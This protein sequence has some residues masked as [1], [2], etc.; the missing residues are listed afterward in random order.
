M[1]WEGIEEALNR[2]RGER[3]RI[4]LQLADLD[5]N[6]AQRM[7]QGADPVGRTRERWVRAERSIH[8]LW[9]VY[10]AFEN[11]VDQAC[12]LRGSGGEDGSVRESLSRVLTG[13]A[14][15][16]PLEPRP[17]ERRGLLDDDTE[18]LSLAEAVARMSAD[19]DE[20]ARVVAEAESA[21][22]VLHPRLGDLEAL[23]QEIGSLAGMVGG[24]ED[25]HEPLRTELAALGET[26]RRDPLSLVAEDD[27]VDTSG[28]ERA[29]VRF[30]RTA[31]ELRD[32]LRMRDSYDESAERLAWAIDDAEV[33]AGRT[34]A[35]RRRVA[36]AVAVPAP[37]E[38]PDAVPPLRSG[39]AQ[40]AALRD[41]GR[42][43]ELGTLHGRL[44]QAV[45]E[46][47]DDLTE[48]EENLQGLLDRRGELRGRLDGYR[49]RAV[50]LGLAEDERLLTEDRRA[51]RALWRAPGD[52]RE[53]TA[54]LAA[55]RDA[56]RQVAGSGCGSN[57]TTPGAGASEGR[58]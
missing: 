22:E 26:I 42:W 43:R 19:Y 46:T 9:T 3:T 21:W 27:T 4:S 2:V 58:E 57:R 36:E 50:R 23:W 56:L 33:K 52:L 8:R 37:I 48:R 32:A 53:A 47:V 34:A 10:G 28:L 45:H 44:Q 13:P 5:R 6:V 14:V 20:A 1:S 54:A 17:L 49:A 35:L 7:L 12:A 55:Y 39:L 11:V 38:V 41:R 15:A 51:Q 16:L 40:M 30:E 29:R 25:D 24:D 18:H 31:G